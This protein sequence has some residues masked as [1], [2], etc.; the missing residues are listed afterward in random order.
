MTI[1]QREA[2]VGG[3]GWCTGAMNDKER[4]LTS[5]RVAAATFHVAPLA[6]PLRHGLRL[7]DQCNVHFGASIAVL[8]RSGISPDL[9]V[10]GRPPSLHLR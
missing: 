9:A 6:G 7:T 10:F 8:D 2:A 1:A 3:D 5:A 4:Q